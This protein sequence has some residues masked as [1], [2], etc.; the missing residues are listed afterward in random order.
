M[1]SCAFVGTPLS[2]VLD[3]V[4]ICQT[5]TF[6]AHYFLSSISFCQFGNLLFNR[7]RALHMTG[8]PKKPSPTPNVVPFTTISEVVKIEINRR[9][10][11]QPAN[12]SREADFGKG[13]VGDR[14]LR[15]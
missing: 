2:S 5:S 3:Y 8:S 10:I 15:K 14:A 13:G 9:G 1:V 7:S 11:R 4:S 6:Q 12:L